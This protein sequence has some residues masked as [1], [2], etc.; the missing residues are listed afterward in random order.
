MDSAQKK[1]KA[2]KKAKKITADYLHNAGLYYLGRFSASSGQF[3][4]VMLRK[5]K[6]SCQQHP[7]QDYKTCVALLGE[8]TEKFIRAGLLNDELYTQGAVKSLRRQ[9]KSRKAIVMKLQH[10][11]INPGLATEKLDMHDLEKSENGDLISAI[12]FIRRKKAG[13]FGN[14]DSQ[15]T[16]AALARAGFSYETAHKAL[17]LSREDAETIAGL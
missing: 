16:L 10:R 4:A 13:P 6:R 8:T 1:A 11:G 12:I 7:E 5:I 3:R 15:K 9:G 17:G 2:P 14:T